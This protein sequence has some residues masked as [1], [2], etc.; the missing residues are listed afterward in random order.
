MNPRQQDVFPFPVFSFVNAFR[1]TVLFHKPLQ[2][3][4]EG[5][6]HQNYDVAIATSN[7]LKRSTTA[8]CTLHYSYKT[9]TKDSNEVIFNT[10]RISLLVWSVP[11]T[12]SLKLQL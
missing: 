3:T 12:S 10:L 8:V 1:R 4:E 11:L 9:A 5:K 2:A 6:R 7:E